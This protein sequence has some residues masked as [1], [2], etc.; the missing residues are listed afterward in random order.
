MAAYCR[1][2]RLTSEEQLQVESVLAAAAVKSSTFEV[3]VETAGAGAG[4]RFWRP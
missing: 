3:G 2:Y 4:M 1:G